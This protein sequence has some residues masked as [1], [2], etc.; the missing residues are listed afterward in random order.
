MGVVVAAVMVAVVVAVSA[1]CGSDIASDAVS[2]SRFALWQDVRWLRTVYALPDQQASG[3]D[4][5]D[6]A[7]G[8]VLATQRL[9]H[10]VVQR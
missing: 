3:V 2:L 7:G 6:N 4:A 8:V 5:S 1:R 9:R 10:V